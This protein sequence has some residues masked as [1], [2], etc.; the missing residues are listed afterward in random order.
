MQLLKCTWRRYLHP[1]LVLL[2]G[3]FPH[4]STPKVRTHSEVSPQSDDEAQGGRGLRSPPNRPVTHLQPRRSAA[5]PTTARKRGRCPRPPRRGGCR[6]T[7]VSTR[8]AR[9]WP[10][11]G[12]EPGHGDRAR[13]TDAVR[14]VRG[15]VLHRGAPPGVQVD[16]VVRGGEVQPRASRLQRDEEQVTLPPLEG[17]HTHVPLRRGGLPIQVLHGH[18]ACLQRLA[19]Q[20]QVLHELAEDERPAP[21]RRAPCP[22]TPAA[23]PAWRTAGPSPLRRAEGGTRPAAAG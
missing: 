22:P 8:G 16:D 11:L 2:E 3:K 18:A 10:P 23:A 17:L 6:P 20:R 1:R 14:P 15:L 7:R 13:L 12:D 19:R 9:G 21:P 4:S 5:A